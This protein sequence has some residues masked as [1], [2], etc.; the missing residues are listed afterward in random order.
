LKNQ[1][2]DGADQPVAQVGWQDAALYCN[3]LSEQESLRPFYR[4]E[5]GV[6]TGFDPAS[7]G[8]RLPT[9]AEWEWAARSQG[10]GRLLRFPWGDALPVTEKSGNYA[11]RSADD[12][13]G[14]ILRDYDDGFSV[15]APVGTFPA[16]AKGLFDLGGNAAE[17]V[18][19]YYDIPVEESAAATDPL[20]PGTGEHHVIRGSSWAHGGPTELRLSFRDYGDGGRDD[21]GFRIARYLE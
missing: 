17:W 10:G 12:F 2:L 21:V 1:N 6:V 14:T 9:E 3:W 15:S 20:G 19:D 11:D 16:N 4:V 13:V 18:H 7:P 8:Y 5:N